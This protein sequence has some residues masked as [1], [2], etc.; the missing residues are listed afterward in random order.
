MPPDKS[1]SSKGTE[2]AGPIR[3][4][5]SFGFCRVIPKGD[6]PVSS[7]VQRRQR[8]LWQE[9]SKESGGFVAGDSKGDSVPFGTRLSAESLVCYTLSEDRQQSSGVCPFEAQAAAFALRRDKVASAK[10]A[11][12]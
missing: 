8:L 9:E 4:S 7:G 6:F 11:D 3:R 2:R 5:C 12:I 10:E 1:I